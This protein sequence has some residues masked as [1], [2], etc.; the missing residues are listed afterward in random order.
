MEPN[1]GIS[2]GV[3][4]RDLLIFQLKL[5]LDGL[6]DIVLIQA[7]IAAVV[8]DLLFGRRGRPLLFYHVLR[9]SER[10]DLWL[11]LHSAAA[12]AEEQADGL[13]GA[14]LAGSQS[15]LGKL[16]QLVRSKVDSARAV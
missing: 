6:K 10:F 8:L 13:F 5:V 9:L 14:S 16:E 7:S 4:I 1:Q 11:S 15:L 12:R 2:R 3:L